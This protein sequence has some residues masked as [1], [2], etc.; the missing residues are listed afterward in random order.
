MGV[1]NEIEKHLT[2]NIRMYVTPKYF[3]FTLN[4]IHQPGKLNVRTAVRQARKT[5]EQLVKGIHIKNKTRSRNPAK[6]STADR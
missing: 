3:T 2:R 4:A 5:E 6:E 1:D